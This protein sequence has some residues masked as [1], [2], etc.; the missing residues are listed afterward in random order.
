MHGLTGGSWKRNRRLPRQ[1]PTLLVDIPLITRRVPAGPG[2][3]NQQR[4]EPLHP[5]V[6]RDMSQASFIQHR[7]ICANAVSIA[8][9][10]ASALPRHSHAVLRPA[11]TEV[12]T[13]CRTGEFFGGDGSVFVRSVEGALYPGRPPGN[14]P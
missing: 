2:R 14:G 10:A 7:V 3:I 11:R 1:L 12:L 8:I 6:D 9:F 5:P 4:S 13:C